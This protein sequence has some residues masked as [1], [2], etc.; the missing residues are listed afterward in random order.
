MN[1]TAHTRADEDL[2]RM[3][4][5]GILSEWWIWYCPIDGLVLTEEPTVAGFPDSLRC[6]H[7]GEVI[8]FDIADTEV[9]FTLSHRDSTGVAWG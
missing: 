5:D 3:V 2:A 6:P 4:K 1:S 7:C 9:T 8:V